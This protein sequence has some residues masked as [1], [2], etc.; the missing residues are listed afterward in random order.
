MKAF[1]AFLSILLLLPALSQSNVS[2]QI[3]VGEFELGFRAGYADGSWEYREYNFN[4]S[5]GSKDFVS[6]YN[7]GYLLAKGVYSF[8][9]FEGDT[10]RYNEGFRAGYADGSWEYREYNF[11]LSAKGQDEGFVRGYVNGYILGHLEKRAKA[12][13]ERITALEK[14]NTALESRIKTLEDKNKALE[15]SVKAL[16]AGVSALENRISA[17]EKK[18]SE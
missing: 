11:N 8:M 17:L 18:V 1:G 13:E 16:E 4:L 6:G 2:E 15:T 14:S 10:A 7:C 5:A 3:N 9:P 12:E